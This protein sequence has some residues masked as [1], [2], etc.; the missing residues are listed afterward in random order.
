[1]PLFRQGNIGQTVQDLQALLNFAKPIPP[2]LKA[3]GMFGPKTHSRVTEFQRQAALMADGVVGPK[4]GTALASS[5]FSKL[6]K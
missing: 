1:M 6:S 5:V 3:D 4:T 2:L